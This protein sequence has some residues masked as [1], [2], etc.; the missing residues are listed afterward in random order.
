M[1]EGSMQ[2]AAAHND[3]L[4]WQLPWVAQLQRAMAAS[5]VWPSRP[6]PLQPEATQQAIV[7]HYLLRV[8]EA[9][10]RPGASCLLLQRAA[11]PPKRGRLQHISLPH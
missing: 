9:V 7:Q 6:C 1:L 2:L 3:A 11:Q 4:L 10:Q 5:L 8:A